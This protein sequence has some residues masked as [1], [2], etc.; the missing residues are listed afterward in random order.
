MRCVLPAL[1]AALACAPAGAAD[2][3]YR[4]PDEAYPQLGLSWRPAAGAIACQAAWPHPLLPAVV[5]IGGERGLRVSADAGATWSAPAGLPA[6]AVTA[7]AWHPGDPAVA[8]AATPAGLWRSGDGGR[9]FAALPAAAP[10]EP[11][12]LCWLPRSARTAAILVGHSGATAGMSFSADGGATWRLLLPEWQVH[13]IHPGALGSQ[14]LALV[15]SSPQEPQVRSLLYLQSPNEKPVEVQRDCAIAAGA[16]PVHQGAMRFAS[17]RDGILALEERHNGFQEITTLPLWDGADG[18]A[19]LDLCWGA[20]VDRQLTFAFDPYGRGAVYSSDGATWIAAGG[21]LPVGEMV[22]EGAAFRANANGSRFWAIINDRVYVGTPADLRLDGLAL[23]VDPPLATVLGGRYGEAL[24]AL[25]G[26]LAAFAAARDP[27]A[28][29]RAAQPALD[30][31]DAAVQPA[32]VR[33]GARI[34]A[35]AAPRRVTV[36]LSRFG[37]SPAEPLFDDGRHGDGAAGDG[38]WAAEVAIRPSRLARERDDWRRSPGIIGLSVTA[39]WA[40]GSRS[41]AVAPLLAWSQ[42]ESQDLFLERKA[43]QQLEKVAAVQGAERAITIGGR[44]PELSLTAQGGA[45]TAT[46]RLDYYWREVMD[47]SP[48][49]GIALQWKGPPGTLRLRDRP[50]YD[51]P[52][53]GP[54]VAMPPGPPDPDGWSTVR[55]PLDALIPDDGAFDRNRVVAVVLSGEAAAGA[56]C[57][58]RLP[59]LLTPDDW[60]AP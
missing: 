30:L 34:A 58:I 11:A 43:E 33:L 15:A 4:H 13:A 21:G 57:A 10:A 31:L 9:S 37:Q 25:S 17:P 60:S 22:K 24:K 41:G 14:A 3:L 19:A 32:A 23:S 27:L 18:V 54:P 49:A 36:D 16:V 29:A 47:V 38:L 8:L 51:D 26:G 53:E 7:F 35:A 12:A 42:A 5:A 55:I 45:W 20:H 48:Y 52:H 2:K 39:H 50:L 6:G 40:D 44:G 46:I 59:R 56:A 1:L 28:A